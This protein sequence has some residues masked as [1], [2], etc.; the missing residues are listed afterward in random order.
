MLN[1]KCIFTANVH[2]AIQEEGG[3]DVIMQ[4]QDLCFDEAKLEQKARQ[5]SVD[6]R[7]REAEVAA[8]RLKAV[9]QARDDAALC[10]QMFQNNRKVI[11][12][13]SALMVH[14]AHH[15]YPHYSTL[16]VPDYYCVH[17]CDS[18]GSNCATP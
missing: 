14:L 7:K 1:L 11:L 2:L 12:D 6:Q 4:L 3:K 18:R 10:L 17:A 9:I 13:S 8:E 5:A 16:F 15:D